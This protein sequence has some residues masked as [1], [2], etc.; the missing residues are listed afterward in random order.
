MRNLLKET[1]VKDIKNFKKTY[2]DDLIK[3]KIKKY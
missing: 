2:M 3:N 1:V